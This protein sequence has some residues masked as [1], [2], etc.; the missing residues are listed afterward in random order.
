VAKIETYHENDEDKKEHGNDDVDDVVERLA[1]QVNGKLDPRI[2]DGAYVDHASDS[3]AVY[4][5]SDQPPYVYKV[6][7]RRLTVM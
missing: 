4:T 7:I 3:M 1:I 2:I 6:R 5:R